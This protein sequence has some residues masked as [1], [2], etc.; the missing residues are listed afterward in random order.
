MPMTCRVSGH[1]KRPEIDRVAR[2]GVIAGHSET[3]NAPGRIVGR[4]PRSSRCLSPS[5]QSFPRGIAVEG[6]HEARASLYT[7]PAGAEIICPDAR[8]GDS[9][10][11]ASA[12]VIVHKTQ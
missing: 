2:R 8:L 1:K 6:T 5:R 12:G 10:L 9:V 7:T 3:N 4:R 11:A